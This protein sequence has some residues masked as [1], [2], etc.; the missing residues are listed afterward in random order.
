MS[1][2]YEHLTDFQL[3]RAKNQCVNNIQ[4]IR[5][6]RESISECSCLPTDSKEKLILILDHDEYMSTRRMRA[7]RNEEIRRDYHFQGDGLKSSIAIGK[8]YI[9]DTEQL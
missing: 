7:Y 4:K 8:D 3:W 2:E 9:H 1:A 5:E 6:L